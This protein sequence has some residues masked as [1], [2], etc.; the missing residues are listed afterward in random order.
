MKVP[1]LDASGTNW[2]VYKDRFLWS[3][4]AQGLLDHVDGSRREPTRPAPVQKK[5]VDASGKET[6]EIGDDD[7]L[8]SDWEEKL[9]TWKQGEA[10]VKQQ[11]A[12]TIPVHESLGEGNHSRNLEGAY[13]GLSE[14][15]VDGFHRLA[16]PTPAVT[17]CRKGRCPCS[18]LD[19]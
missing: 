6:I 11:I 5:V 2:V 17:V 18:L 8:L 14:Q 19:L 3:V 1:K 10:V 9:K 13:G 4:D 7:K 12:A 15:V 16:T